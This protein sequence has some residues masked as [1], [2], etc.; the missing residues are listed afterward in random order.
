M[1]ASSNESIDS[2]NPITKK[3]SDI[4]VNYDLHG[5]AFFDDIIDQVKSKRKEII[6]DLYDTMN[7]PGA[8]PEIKKAAESRMDDMSKEQAQEMRTIQKKLGLYRDKS[9]PNQSIFWEKES[10][11]QWEKQ[12]FMELNLGTM[13]S[14]R[15][16]KRPCS[17]NCPTKI[18]N[19]RN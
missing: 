10:E 4:D 12:H 18:C 1:S 2:P 3:L 13:S 6:R 8:S 16:Y 19:V 9:G 15:M 7:H 14:D 11:R 17:P 5:Q